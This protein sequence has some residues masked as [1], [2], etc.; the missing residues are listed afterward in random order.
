MGRCRSVLALLLHVCV[1]ETVPELERGELALGRGG[2]GGRRSGSRGRAEHEWYV[3][4]V[5]WSRQ[6]LE[7]LVVVVVVAGDVRLR[8][9]LKGPPTVN[10][11]KTRGHGE[12]EV[13]FS[14]GSRRRHRV[15]GHEVVLQEREVRHIGVRLAA[16]RGDSDGTAGQVVVV[17]RRGHG[18]GRNVAEVGS[19]GGK[20]VR[21]RVSP[22][23]P[24]LREPDVVG[25]GG[26]GRRLPGHQRLLVVLV[27]G[28]G[29]AAGRSHPR[30]QLGEGCR[31]R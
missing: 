9:G 14:G 7:L 16:A 11:Q 13:V 31:L 29:G 17:L 20:S 27:F 22:A 1:L 12:V 21:H 4:S 19:G 23:L 24:G 6:P 8:I 28:G 25:G 30:E 18:D 15:D 26:D 5:Q 10:T 3:G 2:R